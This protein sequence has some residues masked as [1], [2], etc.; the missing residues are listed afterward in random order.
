MYLD[1]AFDGLLFNADWNLVMFQRIL[2]RFSADRV[3]RS[4]QEVSAGRRN[5]LNIPVI[6]AY[7][8][9][10][11]ELAAGVCGVLVNEIAAV[12]H[13]VHCTGNGGIALCGSGFRV[14]L[15]DGCFPLFEHVREA[16]RCRFVGFNRDRLR[17]WLH[18]LI[19]HIKLGHRVAAGLQVWNNDCAVCTSLHSCVHAVTR[20][21][22]P[23]T[24]NLAIL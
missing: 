4:I 21:A 16:Y 9:F 22:E 12:I 8:L 18:V 5:L 6:P 10:R 19:G 17:L 24:G 2:V 3:F 23:Y 20:H 7:V 14:H 11:R 1:F 15:C 13:A